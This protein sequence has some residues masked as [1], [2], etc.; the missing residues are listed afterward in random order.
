LGK[1]IVA[2]LFLL[3]IITIETTFLWNENAGISYFNLTAENA[4]WSE[5]EENLTVRLVCSHFRVTV[6]GHLNAELCYCCL[7][8]T[9]WIDL[10]QVSREIIRVHII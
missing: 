7:C 10:A 5:E 4:G 9:V 8:M 3:A 6:K 2:K 1:K